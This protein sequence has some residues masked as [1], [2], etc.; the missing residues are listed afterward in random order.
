MLSDVVTF[1]FIGF[2]ENPE[3]QVTEPSEAT[4]VAPNLDDEV[5]ITSSGNP[6]PVYTFLGER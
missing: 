4:D 5:L 2:T 3:N 1:E 6:F